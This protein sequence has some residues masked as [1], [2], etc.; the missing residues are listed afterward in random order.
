M[1]KYD[2]APFAALNAKAYRD[3]L[4]KYPKRHTVFVTREQLEAICRDLEAYTD[5]DADA[6][7]WAEQA[8]KNAARIA[9]LEAVLEGV[10][11]AIAMERR[12]L[13][14]SLDA[15]KWIGY[16]TPLASVERIA[17]GMAIVQRAAQRAPVAEQGGTP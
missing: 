4:A 10:R 15:D 2:L 7:A 12:C 13:E 11:E 14:D 17:K 3:Y 5:R 6:T 8:T 1:A 16:A 9:E